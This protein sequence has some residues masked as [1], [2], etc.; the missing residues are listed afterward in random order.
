MANK[1]H[2][3]KPVKRD[4][5][6]CLLRRVPRAYAAIE[7]RTHVR[8][9]TGIRVA[10]DPRALAASL[11]V[12]ELDTNLQ[13][14]WRSL[15]NGEDP[16]A[17]KILHDAEEHA[18]AIGLPI[19]GFDDVFKMGL[20]A[21]YKRLF[22][23]VGGMPLADA[24]PGEEQAL[25]AKAQL[26]VGIPAREKPKPANGLR[27]SQMLEEYERINA[28]KIAENAPDQTHEGHVHRQSALDVFCKA[29]GE[30]P[31]IADLTTTHT[32]AFR[33]HWQDRVL[34]GEVKA[35]SANRRMR[36]VSGMFS[37]IQNFHQLDMKNPFAGIRFRDAPDSKRP[38][39]PTAYIQSHFLSD[40]TFDDLD[41]E[42]R[43][44]IYLMIETGIR[45]SEACGLDRSS[46]LLDA[47]IPHVRVTTKNRRT[48][49]P[50]SARE[51]PLLGVAL[52]AMQKQPD[53]FPTYFN[54]PKVL[55][56][57][58]GKFLSSKDMNVNG[59]TLYSLRHSLMTRL[60][61]VGAPKT[62][63]EDLAGHTHMYGD[64]TDIEVRYTWMQKIVL[65]PPGLV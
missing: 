51:I 46:I 1:P 12:I 50:G 55:S 34:K 28:T 49:T 65:R 23:A 38:T 30:D 24:R 14:Y 10:D 43:R 21:L 9:S 4:G 35:N 18:K 58:I 32:H 45:P 41:E 36:T 20:P 6:W 16:R 33:A 31:Y 11:K 17:A 15:A 13:A 59:C 27:V 7:Q 54:R 5:Y 26:A 22:A 37:C 40:N 3:A 8:V 60:R 52:M 44:F 62:V 42:A 63:Q 53:G 47:K 48:K 56:T 2:P 29:I 39:Y 57:H 64:P 61:N 19:M 25:V